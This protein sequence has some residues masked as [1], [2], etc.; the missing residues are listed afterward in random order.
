MLGAEQ[1]G[2]G[3]GKWDE[4]GDE[5]CANFVSLEWEL[6]RLLSGVLSRFLR[7]AAGFLGGLP[8]DWLEVCRMIDAPSTKEAL[9]SRC[10]TPNPSFPFPS[11]PIVHMH[12]YIT[13]HPTSLLIAALPKHI[14]VSSPTDPC[15]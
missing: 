8:K 3:G 2:A 14:S 1:G 5:L 4:E 6:F 10:L 13:H 11:L 7:M 9:K 12:K 15:A